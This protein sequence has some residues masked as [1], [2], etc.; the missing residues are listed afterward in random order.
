MGPGCREDRTTILHYEL[1]VLTEAERQAKVAL[2]RAHG[3]AEGFQAPAGGE[4]RPLV[5]GPAKG[6]PRPRARAGRL[7][8]GV[9]PVPERPATPPWGATLEARVPESARRGEAVVAEVVAR[10]T[11]RL[12]WLPPAGPWPQLHLSHHVLTTA[13]LLVRRDGE[14]IP[15]PRIVAPGESARFLF[16]F[17][18]P[19]EPG[20]YLLEWDLV[21]EGECWFAECG[22]RTARVRLEVVD[23]GR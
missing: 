19:D 12:D 9:E 18:T 3:S 16:N 15:M 13:G 21:S 4:R 8:D 20:S 5:P 10:N 6:A 1:L 14:R 11:G 22:G 23:H 2:Y 7:L 17:R